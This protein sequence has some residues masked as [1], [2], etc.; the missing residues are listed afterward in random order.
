MNIKFYPNESKIY[1]F[2]NFPKLIYY[3]ESYEELKNDFYEEM[4]MEDYLKFVKD[5]AAKLEPYRKEIEEYYSK[6]F[7]TDYNFIDLSIKMDSIFGFDNEAEFLNHLLNLNEEKI[8]ERTV[9]SLVKL[10]K[11]L[12]LD[13]EEIEN[14][15][16]DICKDK[17][18]ILSY[19]KGL[20]IDAGI[21]WKLF[22]SV[23]NPI[24]YMKSYVELMLKILPIF[25][26]I[27][28]PYMAEVTSYGSFLENTIIEKGA[29]GISEL[30]FSIVDADVIDADEVC[31]LVT[32][33]IAYSLSLNVMKDKIIMAWGLKMGDAFMQ[34]KQI[35]ENKLNER[36]Q[37]FKNLGDKTRYEVLRHIAAGEKSMK[38]ISE[39][40]NVST[41]T[42]SYHVSNF[43][44]S[45]VIKMDRNKNKYGYLIDY[46]LLEKTIEDFKK[47]LKFPSIEK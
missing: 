28:T 47:D 41:A 39:A 38:A 1:D 44:T 14:N 5:T 42:I 25:D 10:N 17:N 29:E 22:L 23:E 15:V 7:I 31:L 19:I 11:V 24:E 26:E 18:D 27:Y 12:D 37:I 40:L 9:Y 30:T 45:K 20:S 21:K 35:N 4:S 36:V 33:I 16:K 2:L 13:D 32:P 3:I 46:E 8:N 34:M 6:P 43:L